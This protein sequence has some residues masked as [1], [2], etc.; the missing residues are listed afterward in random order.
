MNTI[1]IS[2]QRCPFYG[3][4]LTCSAKAGSLISSEGNVNAL[5]KRIKIPLILRSMPDGKT[6]QEELKERLK[7]LRKI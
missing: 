5:V 3:W 2:K 6:T 4:M 7:F 1:Y